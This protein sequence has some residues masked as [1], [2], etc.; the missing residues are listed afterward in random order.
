M[1]DQSLRARLE[2]EVAAREEAERILEKRSR[3]LTAA[4]EEILE[5]A[6]QMFD[7]TEQLV[8]ILN[9][10]AAGIF[11]VNEHWLIQRANRPVEQIFAVQRG[12][13]VGK[14]IE[15]VLRPADGTPLLDLAEQIRGRGYSP[16]EV[17][18]VRAPEEQIEVELHISPVENNGRKQAVWSV[19]DITAKKQAERERRALESELQQAH[20]M[21]SL[22]TLSSGIAHEINTP[23][24][25]I[26]DNVR[27][28]K[29][30]F[31]DL[32]DILEKSRAALD[33]LSGMAAGSPA[34]VAAET[35]LASFDFDYLKEEIPSALSQSL[36]GLE[37]VSNIVGA[38][39]EFA[40]PGSVE[41]TPSNINAL[42]RTTATVSR[43]QWKYLATL[44]LDL[45]SD[46]PPVPCLA[47]EI[48]QVLLNLIVNAAQAIEATGRDG[49]GIIRIATRV[50][51]DA[52]EILVGD[53][54]CGI[55]V[56]VQGRV[57]D[58]FFTTKGVGK[59]TGQGLALAYACIT[60]RHGGTIGFE[61]TANLG[62]TFR[63]TLPIRDRELPPPEA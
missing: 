60:K 52:V 8:T 46:L 21:E 30:S 61:S 18:L 26:S 51:D 1:T 16:L 38:I 7:H 17:R 31:D 28:L 24:Q 62:T 54:G 10:S 14:P 23:I 53:D 49:P 43:N 57:F 37:Q 58:P 22:G 42:I 6:R 19:R 41:L 50:R 59:G 47:G 20:K 34:I 5:S 40:H 33:Q 12:A 29:D 11:L 39:K 3:E 44:E 2:R 4:N 35:S 32:L 56:A 55:P 63:I 15:S 13:L 48:K 9:L 27:F 25:Y 45:A 36:E